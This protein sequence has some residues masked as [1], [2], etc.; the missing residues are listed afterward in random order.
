MVT[1]CTTSTIFDDAFADID[2]AA[3]AKDRYNLG[4]PLRFI[5]RCLVARDIPP[6]HERFDCVREIGCGRIDA[7]LNN[8]PFTAF[9]NLEFYFP[10]Q[11]MTPWEQQRF[12]PCIYHHPST[13]RL[14]LLDI[15]TGSPIIV[16]NFLASEVRIL[17][18]PDLRDSQI[19]AWAG[20]KLGST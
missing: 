7:L 8:R 14:E 10:E 6:R 4:R 13:A 19:N 20:T 1:A 17:S 3:I 2:T 16:G 5:Q 9:W 11:W 15:L 12:V 18:T